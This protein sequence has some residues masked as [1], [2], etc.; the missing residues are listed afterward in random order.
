MPKQRGA[1]LQ[2]GV[3]ARSLQAPKRRYSSLKAGVAT[4]QQLGPKPPRTASNSG[5]APAG[6]HGY[7]DRLA[8]VQKPEGN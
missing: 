5:Q 6:L 2:A 8:E 1:G 4:K 7:A 3:A